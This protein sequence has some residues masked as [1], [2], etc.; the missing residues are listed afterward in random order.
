DVVLE[1]EGV[2]LA[3]RADIDRLGE[4]GHDFVLFVPHDDA[5]EDLLEQVDRVAVLDL[6]R[7]QLGGR[8][9]ERVA[10][11]IALRAA[12]AMAPGHQQGSEQERRHPET[13][14]IRSPHGANI[15]SLYRDT[16]EGP[17]NCKGAKTQR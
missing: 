10:K 17:L 5:L 14:A 12:S 3:V 8:R 6:R 15:L 9:L 16:V 7:V 1:T 2:D 4:V 11:D 13:P